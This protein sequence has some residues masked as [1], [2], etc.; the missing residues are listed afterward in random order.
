[1]KYIQTLM[2]MAIAGLVLA[3]AGST[4]AQTVKPCLVTVVRIQGQAR[5]SMGDNVWHP[6]V[7]GKI[8]HSGAIIQSAVNSSVDLVLSGNRIM[9]QQAP[10][11][12]GATPVAMG[13]ADDPNVRGYVAYQPAVEQNV[14]R[15]FG[16]S[17]LAV[18]KLSQVDTGVD[19]VSDTELD[20]RAGKI[21]VNV[22]KMS[23][24][25]QFIIKIPNGVAGIRGSAGC[26]SADGSIQWFKGEIII[27]LVNPKTG[28][29]MTTTVNGGFEY[30]PETGQVTEV[31]PNVLNFLRRIGISVPSLYVETI[32]LSGNGGP[33]NL[34]T[35]YVSPV[36]NDQG[37]N[38]N[39]QGQNQN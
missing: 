17:V 30:N 9:M 24:S 18:D 16:N 14:I 5:Y 32:Q 29:P 34:A 6:L 1:M 22:K 19:T 25:S 7:V 8:L 36:Q 37:Q 26:I 10:T 3:F 23:A 20:L 21:F 27:S 4:I 35:V 31:T 39:N 33:H 38:N 2:T 12:P 15:M 28:Q 11:S 13:L